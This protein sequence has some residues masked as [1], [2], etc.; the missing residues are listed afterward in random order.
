MAQRS[1]QRTTA[2]SAPDTRRDRRAQPRTTR[3]QTQA[4]N[5]QRRIVS[6]AAGAIILVIAALVAFRLLSGSQSQ[7]EADQPAPADLVA[8]VTGVPS[9][10]AAVVGQGSAQTLPIAAGGAPVTG[11]DGKPTITYIGAEFCP[12]C[13]AE[14]WPMIAALSRFG[15]FANLKT[16]ASAPDDVYP[17]TPTFSFYGA[18]YTS[19]YVNLDAVETTTNQRSGNGYQPLQTP[20][21]A[22]TQLIRTYHAPPYVPAQSAG[23]IPFISFANMYVVSGASYDIGVLRGLTRDQIAANLADPSS[24]QAKAIVGAANV[25][26]ATICRTTSNTP[27]DVCGQPYVQNIENNLPA[28]PA[29]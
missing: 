2:S 20:T 19:Q 5:R 27:S 24:A 23:S 29:G 11:A 3:Q 18:T 8:Q 28:A 9:S 13:A 4:R 26:T 6:L 16:T 21:A 15:S 22:Q 17:N 7:A 12:F 14:R 10:V 25:L 1:A